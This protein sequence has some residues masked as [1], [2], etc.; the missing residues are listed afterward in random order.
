[1]ARTNE[2]IGYRVC[3]HNVGFYVATMPHGA[4]Y[5]TDVAP[6][7]IPR[8]DAYRRLAAWLDANPDAQDDDYTVD[9]VYRET[10]PIED[11]SN[12]LGGL[13]EGLCARHGLQLGLTRQQINAQIAL[14]LQALQAGSVP[15]VGFIAGG[16]PRIR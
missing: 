4:N 2:V 12:E 1:M 9:P 6:A 11:A 10:T 15:S 8:G 16:I 5:T 3:N 7:P 13:L 14:E